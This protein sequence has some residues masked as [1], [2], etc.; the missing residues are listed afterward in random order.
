MGEQ[1]LVKQILVGWT[2]DGDWTTV[3]TVDGGRIVRI[4]QPQSS[5]K[6]KPAS[7]GSIIRPTGAE[8]QRYSK[9]YA[10]DIMGQYIAGITGRKPCRGCKKVEAGVNWVHKKLVRA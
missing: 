2:D 8:V 6:G 9:Q 10:G 3:L 4:T 1:L 5:S 7:N